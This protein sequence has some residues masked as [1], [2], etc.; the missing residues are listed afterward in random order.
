M[1]TGITAVIMLGC[2]ACVAAQADDKTPPPPAAAKGY[3][4]RVVAAGDVYHGI[5]FKPTTGESWKILNGKW[6]KLDE[7]A[8]PPAGDYEIVIIPAE[9]LL[10]VRF[11]KTSGTTWL[12]Q[13]GKWTAVKEPPAKPGAPKPPGPG[14]RK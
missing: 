1:R 7:A 5:R 2:F 9:S 10:A 14:D 13:D 4:L 11:D 12:L 3:E 8:A 6:E